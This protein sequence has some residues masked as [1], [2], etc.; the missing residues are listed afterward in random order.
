MVLH[1]PTSTTNKV[2]NLVLQLVGVNVKEEY[3]KDQ[4]FCPN[5]LSVNDKNPSLNCFS[6]FPTTRFYPWFVML[7][8]EGK[9]LATF[10]KFNILNKVF[11]LRYAQVYGIEFATFSSALRKF[12]FN[13]FYNKK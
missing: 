5:F 9:K 4:L 6:F 10:G 11:N 3:F 1:R 12:R 2:S 7:A 13:D 8:D